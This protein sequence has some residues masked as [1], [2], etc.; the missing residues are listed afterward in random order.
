MKERR[1]PSEVLE[2]EYLIPPVFDADGVQASAGIGKDGKE[3][4]D[5]VPMA[6]PVGFAPPPDLMQMIKRMVRNEQLMAIADKEGFDTFEEAEDFE[7]EDDPLDP[8]TPYEEIFLPRPSP[9]ND[10]KLADGDKGKEAAVA[11]PPPV[12]EE[13]QK[14]STASS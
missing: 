12:K 5:P 10:V 7:I 13:V 6:P 2:P 4:G 11:S 8:L 1:K 9:V 3:Y 14:D